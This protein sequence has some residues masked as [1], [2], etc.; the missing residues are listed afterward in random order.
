M[1]SRIE[2]ENL[3]DHMKSCTCGKHGTPE[4]ATWIAALEWV[5]GDEAFRK[6][7]TDQW[8]ALYDIAITSS[9]PAVLRTALTIALQRLAPPE[10]TRTV[11]P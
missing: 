10:A 6:A 7:F 9:D 3:L 2:I 11:Q 1:R 8:N 4:N 5:T